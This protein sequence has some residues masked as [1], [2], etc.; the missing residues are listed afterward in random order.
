MEVGVIGVSVLHIGMPAEVRVAARPDAVG[1]FVRMG[2]DVRRS[3]V[4]V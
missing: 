1:V 4:G 2:I 3:G